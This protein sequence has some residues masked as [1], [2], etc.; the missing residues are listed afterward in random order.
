MNISKYI[1]YGI[2]SNHV[3]VCIEK[4]IFSIFSKVFFSLFCP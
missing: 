3:I 4:L 1:F 2:S